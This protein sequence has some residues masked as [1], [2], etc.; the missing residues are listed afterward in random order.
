MNKVIKS[1]GLIV[2]A[3]NSREHQ[4]IRYLLFQR[5]DTYEYMEFL[6]GIWSTT[7][8]LYSLF[9]KMSITERERLRDHSF[10]E[11]WNDLW[12]NSK[13]N[14]YS[15]T[16]TQKYKFNQIK[17]SIPFLIEETPCSVMEPPWGFPKGR[18][19]AR[20]KAKECAIR[21]FTEETK[22]YSDIVISDMPPLS[23]KY[24]G[25]DK[26]K[27]ETKFF[28]GKIADIVYPCKTLFPQGIRK[29][30]ISEES[31]DVGWFTLKQAKEK[32]NDRLYKL[33]EIVESQIK[34]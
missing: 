24:I 26:K 17:S 32:L 11:L 6:R 15:V 7:A 21:E 19:N 4:E 9:S 2:Y 3:V 8:D 33:L 5:R 29:T 23:E 31:N 13:S 34:I 16:M 28:V 20:E 1:Y 12:V 30:F 14:F 22:V 18:K 25:T 10:S 27:Y